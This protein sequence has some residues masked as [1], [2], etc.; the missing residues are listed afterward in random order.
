MVDVERD[1]A[2]RCAFARA[3][4]HLAA[5]VVEGRAPVGQSGQLVGK[6]DPAQSPGVAHLRQR[7]P[8]KRQQGQRGAGDHPVLQGADAFGIAQGGGTQRVLGGECAV[9]LLEAVGVEL[10]PQPRGLLGTPG[11]VQAVLQFD[12]A[13]AGRQRL[14]RL[15]E[16]LQGA[17]ALVLDLFQE[18]RGL[19]RFEPFARLVE[20]A[21]R[22]LRP[23]QVAQGRATG[24]LQCRLHARV[25]RHHRLR[26]GFVQQRQRLGGT[27]Q[28]DQADRHRSQAVGDVAAEA[29]GALHRERRA[30]VL[31]RRC[32]LPQFVLRHAQVVERRGLV[33]APTGLARDRKRLRVVIERLGMLAG[34]A[35][36]VGDGGQ[37]IGPAAAIAERFTGLESSLEVG[38]GVAPGAALVM[39]F[40]AQHARPRQQF[41]VLAGEP[42]SDAGVIGC[43]RLVRSLQAL[44][45]VAAADVQLLPIG[46]RVQIAR[47]RRRAGDQL[48]CRSRLRVNDQP[49][50][51]RH[52]VQP[53]RAVAARI[54]RRERPIIEG[55]GFVS[56]RGR[57]G[58][59]GGEQR[60]RIVVGARHAGR[61]GQAQC[62][63]QSAHRTLPVVAGCIVHSTVEKS[64]R[65]AAAARPATR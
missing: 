50:L 46:R 45:R 32:G 40:A 43:K 53:V 15:P 13:L 25:I 7:Q 49:A 61:Q 56:A 22:L 29:G 47:Q 18:R 31:Q 55:A 30:V 23:V 6:R 8:R 26:R 42:G 35:I 33:V 41:Q 5:R 59:R 1:D 38:Q 60:R 58:V 12:L 24:E 10:D 65:C 4:F 14:C 11:L 48:Q 16:R 3:A 51:A 20:Q 19:G 36:Q 28:L 21:Q 62:G 37:R 17:R 2:E 34:A 63:G 57:Q 52:G 9:L 64:W 54:Q 27:F 44:V 39:Q